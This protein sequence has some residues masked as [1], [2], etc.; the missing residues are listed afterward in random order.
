MNPVPSSKTPLFAQIKLHT[1]FGGGEVFACHLAEAASALGGRSLLIVHPKAKHWSGLSLPDTEILEASNWQ[2]AVARLP[3]GVPVIVHAAPPAEVVDDI[4]RSRPL[5]GFVHMPL[6]QFYAETRHTYSRCDRVVGVSRY[7]METISAVGLTPW[8]EPFYGVANI[9]RLSRGDGLVRASEYEWDRRKVRDRLLG[10]TEPLWSLLRQRPVLTRRNGLS[11][12]IV[13]RLA[14][15]KQFPELMQWLV[16]ELLRFDDVY[17]EIFGA[18]GYASV[19]DL[20][21]VLKPLGDRVR[22]WGHQTDVAQAYAAIDVLL[23]GLPER[24]ALGLNV[25]EAQACGVPVLA[26]GAPPFIETVLPARTGWLYADPRSGRNTGGYPDFAPTL[27]QILADRAAGK[28]LDPRLATDHMKCFSKNEFAQRLA[29]LLD[30]L[31]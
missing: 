24:E 2:E 14:P 21:R 18:G 26:P 1:Y 6:N 8:S 16:P 29:R 25:I 17:L 4:A 5:I 12:G 30:K 7:V 10:V 20:R 23:T 3:A 13:S 11:L 31:H 28:L 22:F 9:S 27:A 15:I 19:R